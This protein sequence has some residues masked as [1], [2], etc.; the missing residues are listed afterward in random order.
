MTK[1]ELVKMTGSE[2][3]AEYAMEILL[4]H[5]KPDMIRLA[6][7]AELDS[8]NKE[9]EVLKDEGYAVTCNGHESV[10]WSKA[11]KLNGWDLSPEQQ[12]AYDAAYDKC[13]QVDRLLYR[14]NRTTD[15]IAYRR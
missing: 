7:K 5:I 8:I 14:R 3:Q 15:L 13:V 2:E 11:E 10:C 6:V 4:K 9:I 1:Q 12:A